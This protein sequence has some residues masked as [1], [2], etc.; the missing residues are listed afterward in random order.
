MACPVLAACLGGAVWQWLGRLSSSARWALAA[1]SSTA[2]REA[3][4]EA[5]TRRS[6]DSW[7]TASVAVST[8][9]IGSGSCDEQ[10]VCHTP[11]LLR[12]RSAS[13]GYLPRAPVRSSHC[14][15]WEPIYLGSPGALP[16]D[17]LPPLPPHRPPSP[18]SPATPRVSP[19]YERSLRSLICSRYGCTAMESTSRVNSRHCTSSRYIGRLARGSPAA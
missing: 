9:S 10:E 3:R 18:V 8:R 7:M 1:V 5:G 6:S 17:A 12:S 16:I 13:I 14:W 15:R 11:S 4:T 2:R 19:G